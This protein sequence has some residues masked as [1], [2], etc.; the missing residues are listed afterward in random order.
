MKPLSALVSIAMLAVS[1]SVGAQDAHGTKDEAVAMAKAAVSHI[2]DVGAEQAYKDFNDAGNAAWHKKDLYVFVTRY[3]GTT[4]ANGANVKLVGKDVSGLKDQ[5]GKPF[6]ADMIALARKSGSGWVDYS[7][8]HPETR[9]PQAKAS[10]VV[11]TP[12]NDA[13]L[14]VGIYR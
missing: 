14:G 8:P 1:L 12:G 10:Y 13:A 6:I 9:K 7:W 11:A 4:L 5:D 2:K 3:D